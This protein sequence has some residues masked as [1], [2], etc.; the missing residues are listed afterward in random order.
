M[1]KALVAL[2]GTAVLG[3]FPASAAALQKALGL[4]KPP[5]TIS[6]FDI[7][8]LGESDKVASLVFFERGKPKKS[9]YRHFRIRS[10]EG[11]DDFAAMREVVTRWVERPA[12]NAIRS[13]YRAVSRKAA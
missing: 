3:V 6:C 4:A 5:V 7:S 1:R 9:E 13:R 12:M 10:V 8:N 11:Q 2:L